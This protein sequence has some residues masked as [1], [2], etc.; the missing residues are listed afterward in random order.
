MH[1]QLLIL[2]IFSMLSFVASA[3]TDGRSAEDIRACSRANFPALTAAQDFDLLVTDEMGSEQK[4]H[5]KLNWRLKDGMSQVNLCFKAPPKLAGTCYLVLEREGM[6]DIH[7]FLP[8]LN[9]V[10]R[11]V[12]S[13]TSQSLL[14][15]DISYE[16]LKHLRAVAA[17]GSLTRL[18]DSKVGDWPAYVLEGRADPAEASPYTRVVSHIDQATCVPLQVDFYEVGD[19]QRKRLSIERDSLVEAEGRWQIRDLSIVDLRDKGSTQV[20]FSDVEYDDKIA[21]RVFNKRSFYVLP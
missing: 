3:E 5:G 16:D 13:A 20:K 12:G 21:S 1:R 19:V 14:G 18:E 8:A 4:M 6:D 7:A 10:K 17:G 11:I 15:T 9:K 2:S